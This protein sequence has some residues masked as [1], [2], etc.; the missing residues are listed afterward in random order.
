VY[1]G[2]RDNKRAAVFSLEGEWLGAVGEKNHLRYV[3]GVAVDRE[4]GRLAVG[5]W[6]SGNPTVQL[7]VA[8]SVSSP[9]AAAL[10]ASAAIAGSS[11]A[12][13]NTP[14]AS[15]PAAALSPPSV[16]LIP[17]PAAVADPP[18]PSIMPLTSLSVGPAV[19]AAAAASA[20]VSI[21]RKD[22]GGGGN[23]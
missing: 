21:G 6:A 15:A 7:F 16:S 19:T 13:G 11:A 9:P 1:V 20:M 4:G 3:N 18:T 17:A 5:D 12:A 23:S 10:A 22:G 2:D 8:G 14:S